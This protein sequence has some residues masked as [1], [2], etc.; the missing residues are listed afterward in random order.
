[1]EQVATDL[2]EKVIECG[3][4]PSDV[5]LEECVAHQ[6]GTYQDSPE[7]VA[8]YY[9]NECLATQTCEEL[10][11]LEILHIGDCLDERNETSKVQCDPF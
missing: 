1:M 5:T 9:F 7:C 8:V 3:S 4:H 6:V 2:C 10:E 11:R